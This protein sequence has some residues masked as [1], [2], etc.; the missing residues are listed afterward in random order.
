MWP[1]PADTREGKLIF[2]V[3]SVLE[4]RPGGPEGR[5]SP[6]MSDGVA[7][8]ERRMRPLNAYEVPLRFSEI[9]PG[10]AMREKM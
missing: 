6:D 8:C 9:T 5:L 3:S 7:R 4:C 10:G 2:C 1:Y